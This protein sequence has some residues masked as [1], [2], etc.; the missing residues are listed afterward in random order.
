MN[1]SRTKFNNL[2]KITPWLIYNHISLIQKN[3]YKMKKGES[4]KKVW[5]E[6][7]T[8]TGVYVNSVSSW[9]RWHQTTWLF[10]FPPSN[11]ASSAAVIYSSPLVIW[12]IS[13]YL[14]Y[15]VHFVEFLVTVLSITYFFNIF[16][17]WTVPLSN[18][19]KYECFSLWIACATFILQLSI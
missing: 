17:G 10:S 9:P 15:Q 8:L 7:E 18:T 1:K 6:L 13:L 2:V 14:W 11:L 12:I 5:G 3:H 16:W 19:F 4:S